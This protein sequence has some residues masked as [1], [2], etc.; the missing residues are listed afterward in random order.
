MRTSNAFE[1]AAL[2]A[3]FGLADGGEVEFRTG[4]RPATPETAASGTLL[5]SFTL[6][7]PG[8]SYAGG[9]VNLVGAPLSATVVAGGDVGYARVRTN[10]GSLGVADLTV[11]LVGGGGEIQIDAASLTLVLGRT[12]QLISLQ[13]NLVQS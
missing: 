13:T 7:T 12:V 4:A 6:G 3:G 2:E 10:F 9:V 5:C 1:E 8:F 11:S